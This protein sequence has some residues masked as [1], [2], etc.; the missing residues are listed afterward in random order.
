MGNMIIE[1]EWTVQEGKPTYAC[2]PG[3]DPSR[4][5]AFLDASNPHHVSGKELSGPNCS[6]EEFYQRNGALLLDL[7]TGKWRYTEGGTVIHQDKNGK[8]LPIKRTTCDVN[9]V[10]H[11]KVNRKTGLPPLPK[12]FNALPRIDKQ[13]IQQE[14]K[15]KRKNK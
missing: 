15:T 4:M 1:D 14:R 10:A 5:N 9:N 12:G 3:Y 6:E 7:P 13:N 8:A 2:A 11:L